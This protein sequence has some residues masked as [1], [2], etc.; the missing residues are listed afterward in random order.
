[1]LMPVSHRFLFSILGYDLIIYIISNSTWFL[2]IKFREL[3]NYFVRGDIN[4]NEWINAFLP[5]QRTNL[6]CN[7]MSQMDK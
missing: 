5:S 3:P 2:C 1:M 7:F 4:G 6:I